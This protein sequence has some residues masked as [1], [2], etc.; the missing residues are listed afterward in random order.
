MTGLMGYSN[1]S[2]NITD[3]KTYTLE[4]KI[5]LRDGSFAY[6]LALGEL[7]PSRLES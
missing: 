5:V 7:S 6:M 1:T 4:S 2:Y 3:M